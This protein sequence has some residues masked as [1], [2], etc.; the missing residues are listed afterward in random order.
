MT[1]E[2][3]TP[4]EAAEIADRIATRTDLYPREVQALRLLTAAVQDGP[5]TPQ[6][7]VVRAV[8]DYGSH[9]AIHSEQLRH[10]RRHWPSLTRALCHLVAASRGTVAVPREWR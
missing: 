6:E 7:A 9:P 1:A 3:M 2:T 8:T 5:S 4:G 10:V